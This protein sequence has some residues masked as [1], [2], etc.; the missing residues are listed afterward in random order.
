[1][2]DKDNLL[3][4]Y[5][6]KI[7][8]ENSRLYEYFQA[9]R[10]LVDKFGYQAVVQPG[11]IQLLGWELEYLCGANLS[12]QVEATLIRRQNDFIPENDHPLILDCGANIGITALNYKSQFPKARIIAFEPDPEIVP[13]LRHNL[14][15]NTNGEVKVVEAAVWVK[16]G[17]ERWH[18]EG[19]DGSHL[20]FEA[21]DAAKTKIVPT[22]DLCDYLNEPIDLIKMDIEGAEYEVI[23]HI[24]NKLINVKALSIECHLDQLT[25]APFGNLLKVLSEAGFQISINTYGP[26][27]DLIRQ[28]PVLVDHHENYILVAA[29]RSSLASSSSN[30]SW[31][32]NVG[33]APINDHADQI[34]YLAQ[35][36]STS[37]EMLKSYA[38]HGE[39]LLKREILD[40]PYEKELGLCWIMRLENLKSV[41]DDAKHTNR[42]ELLLF[43]D[44]KLLQSAHTMHDDIRDLGAGRYSH[45]G[46][47]LYFSTSDGADPNTNGRTYRIVYRLPGPAKK[48][49]LF[50]GMISRL[51]AFFKHFN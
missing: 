1:M 30:G 41:A 21:N 14:E 32:P 36:S 49:N 7:E 33:L 24:S 19:I 38:L 50:T 15:R 47:H 10:L 37:L 20:S 44:D 11:Q 28:P 27:R 25:I 40:G 39:G 12:G 9:Y 42:S 31:I 35:Q 51:G 43:E 45:W 13:L 18:S 34:R 22:I 29:W 26:W 16:N 17:T 3:A 48:Q 46:E 6:N 23:P 2:L 4:Q 5:L 8:P